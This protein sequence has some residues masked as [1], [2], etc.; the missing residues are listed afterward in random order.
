[1]KNDTHDP[2]S[3]LV[4]IAG[5]IRD[6]QQERGVSDAGWCRQYPGLGT[7][8]TYAL[9]RAGELGELD[10]ARWLQDYRSV[11]NLLQEVDQ[12]AQDDEEF[13]EDLELYRRATVALREAMR[14]TG[15]TRFVVIQA[16][17]GQGKST[18][19]KMMRG[20]YGGSRVR[21]A[22][23]DETWRESV[24]AMV[25]G[26]LEAIGI[27]KVPP[28]GAARMRLLRDTLCANR[29]AL[30][31]DEAH[32]L[33][34]RTLNV[35]KTIVN[36]TPGEVVAMWLPVLGDRLLR[37]AYDE[38]RQLID[39]RLLDRVGIGRLSDD[40]IRLFVGRRLGMEGEALD[41]APAI[42]R[43]GLPPGRASVN[44]TFLKLVCRRARR[45]AAG[46]RATVE[47]FSRAVAQVSK[48]R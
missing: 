3:E 8:K 44:L 23:A 37:D 38:A 10:V 13:Y 46:G 48:G 41:Q 45:S 2:A 11:W 6:A 31:V 5:K 26:L 32:H 21:L 1:M 34:P 18:W 24:P 28:S 25:G 42:V 40:D 16:E 29:T 30:V 35:L 36:Q 43:S 7:T 4:A 12:A 9:V 39:N 47:A 33:G 27:H 20:R 19:A 22:E 15:L 17:P 14:E